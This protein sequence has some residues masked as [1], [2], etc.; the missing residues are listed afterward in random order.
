MALGVQRMAKKN[1]LIRK[2]PAVET[3][4]SATVICSDKTGTLTLNQMT[5]THIAVNGDFAAGQGTPVA[6]AAQRHP[7]VYQELIY[8]AALC[9]DASLDPDHPGQIIGD[10]TEG[11]L[12][13]LAQAFGIDHEDLEET[14]PRLFE[15]PFDSD[16]KRMTTV[17]RIQDRNIA[18][19]KGA[20]DELLPL[21]THMLTA[22]G[23]RP[24]TETD[25][26][27]ILSLCNQMSE[28][29]LRVLVDNSIKYSPEGGRILLSVR[30]DGGAARMSVQDEGQGIDAESLPHIFDRFFRTD[31]S[32]ARQTGGTGLG[33]SIVRDTVRRHG[34]WVTV[35]ARQPEGSVFTVGFP[36]V[37]ERRKEGDRG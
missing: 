2:L 27:Q 18:Y 22:A 26:R 14:Y 23:V 28:Q 33:L 30:A 25:R 1:A 19:T 12:I 32:R 15:Q 31:Q 9:N 29:A 34:G 13:S 6:E 3:L 36:A 4:G 8:A 21:C 24:M 7:K 16:R 5:V 17:H 37:P 35:R 10:P 20:V 11:A